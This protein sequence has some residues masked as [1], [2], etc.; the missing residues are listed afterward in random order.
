M[1]AEIIGQRL[2]ADPFDQDAQNIGRYR[3]IPLATRIEFQ[4]NLRQRID[5]ALRCI[6]VPTF[7]IGLAVRRVDVASFLKTVG[8]AAGVAKHIDDAHRR[9]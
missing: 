4:R 9:W 8:E 3:V 7:H 1:L 6:L 5:E 2:A